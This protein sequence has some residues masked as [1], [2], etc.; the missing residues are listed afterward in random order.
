MILD[1]D[2]LFFD[3]YLVSFQTI[4]H[5]IA[6]RPFSVAVFENKLYWSDW[7]SNTIQ[8]CD[9]FTGKDWK[10]LART[11]S[12]IYGIH[13]YHSILKPKVDFIF[14]LPESINSPVL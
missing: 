11:N 7:I 2:G 9:K 8:S 1:D 13:I 6:K 14:F 5:G 12:T 4:L 3:L 10:I